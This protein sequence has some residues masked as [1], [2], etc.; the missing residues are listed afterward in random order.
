MQFREKVGK[1]KLRKRQIDRDYYLWNRNSVVDLDNRDLWCNYKS[2]FQYSGFLSIPLFRLTWVH[3][4]TVSSLHQYRVFFLL[5]VYQFVFF[6]MPAFMEYGQELI[7]FKINKVDYF[8]LFSTQAGR[9]EI[10]P[11]FLFRNNVFHWY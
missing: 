2:L 6:Q 5:P 9:K 7:G 1:N 3:L 11:F 10:P 8:F 4:A